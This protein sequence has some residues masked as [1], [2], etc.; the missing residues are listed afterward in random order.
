MSAIPNLEFID[1]LKSKL[2]EEFDLGSRLSRYESMSPEL[3]EFAKSEGI[4]K[5][6]IA[7]RALFITDLKLN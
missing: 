3:V 2:D 7:T 5:T 4:D 6:G 1:G